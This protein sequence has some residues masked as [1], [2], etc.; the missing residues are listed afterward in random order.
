MARQWMPISDSLVSVELSSDLETR[1][2]LRITSVE[3]F[4]KCRDTLHFSRK[5]IASGAIFKEACG[6]EPQPW[7][8]AFMENVE[9]V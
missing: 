5:C 6:K 3:N 7:K 9:P 8:T 2:I 4:E 1:R